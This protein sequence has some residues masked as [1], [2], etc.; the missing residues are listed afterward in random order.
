MRTRFMIE[1]ISNLKDNRVRS[2][3]ITSTVA[4]EHRVRM[5]KTLGSLNM[6]SIRALEPLRIGVKD[7]QDADKRGKWWLIGASYKDA[8]RD[9]VEPNNFKQN[10][11]TVTGPEEPELFHGNFPDL[12]HLA[13][14]QRMN[15]DIRRS[16]FV[17]VMSAVDYEDAHSR[18]QK[19]HLRKTQELEIP[20][21]LIHCAAA[22]QT[23]NPFYS[24]LSRRFCS[25]R[26]LKMAFQFSLWSLFKQMG[27]DRDNPEEELN[28]EDCDTL[29]L[30]KIV[31][32]AKMFGFLIAENGLG[33]GVLKVG[34]DHSDYKYIASTEDWM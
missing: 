33:I 10:G 21:V 16:I 25:D 14:E 24:L 1:T 12:V 9:H 32:L 26:K 5:K 23:Y 22:E 30:R 18:L 34:Y 4:S 11:Q 3:A 28:V 29:G 8:D 19:L 7:I 6:R 27:E 15:T 17:A 31:N 2:T 13:R 20:K